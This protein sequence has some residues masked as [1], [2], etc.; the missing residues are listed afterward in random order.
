MVASPLSTV[1]HL[2]GAQTV[3][4]LFEKL[5]NGSVFWLLLIRN[6]SCWV[7][8]ITFI[9]NSGDQVS[10]RSLFHIEYFILVKV[11]VKM[12]GPFFSEEA[13]TMDG[14]IN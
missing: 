1:Y 14:C 11:R 2:Q 10:Y 7:L 4:N 6:T 13:S 9:N 8:R 3:G 12:I 5:T